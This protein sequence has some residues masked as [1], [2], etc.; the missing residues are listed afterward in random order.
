MLKKLYLTLAAALMIALSAPTCFAQ[1]PPVAENES[2][3]SNVISV[4]APKQPSSSVKKE[5][6]DLAV[7]VKA[8]TQEASQPEETTLV[9]GRKVEKT[10]TVVTPMLKEGNKLTKTEAEIK[11]EERKAREKKTREQQIVNE[12]VAR[13]NM[14]KEQRV[15]NSVSLNPRQSQSEEVE[16]LVSRK[17]SELTTPDMDTYH[18][19]KAC[20][21]YLTKNMVYS[22]AYRYMD[23]VIDD[24]VTCGDVYRQYGE[25]EGTGAVALTTNRGQCDGY[26]AAFLLMARQIGLEGRLVD[27]M[28]RR[29]GGGYTYHKWAEID[30]NGQTYVFDPQIE[31]T[32]AR[33]GS[34][35]EYYVFC[36]TYDEVPG[37]YIR[38]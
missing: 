35:P 12:A 8:D 21:D 24:S 1:E 29:R 28:T 20:F 11:V 32:L 15:L 3:G 6:T 13:G 14:S 17:V 31:Q 18:K 34:Y 25:V 27:G 37:R 7:G 16:D 5:E 38:W 4:T 36:K 23:T 26:S 2:K 33:I 10:E 30:L 19:M 9:T 22:S